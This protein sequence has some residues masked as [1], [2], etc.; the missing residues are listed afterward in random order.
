MGAGCVR[1]HHHENDFFAFIPN[2]Y[3]I[4][5]LMM[6]A[7]LVF[8]SENKSLRQGKEVKEPN[9]TLHVSKSTRLGQSH[10]AASNWS[11]LE[12]AQQL[13]LAWQGRPPGGTRHRIPCR[14]MKSHLFKFLFVVA[15]RGVDYPA[16]SRMVVF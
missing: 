1:D 7:Q 2:Q 13:L 4:C 10:H 5:E 11:T 3:Q 14:W 9:P 15:S 8:L 6:L 12:R 16:E